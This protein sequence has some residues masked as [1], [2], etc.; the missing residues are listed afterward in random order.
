MKLKKNIQKWE[1]MEACKKIQ[2]KERKWR[3]IFEKKGG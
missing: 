2:R 3:E 1:K